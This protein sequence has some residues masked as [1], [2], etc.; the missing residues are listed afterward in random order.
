VD[1]DV[2]MEPPTKVKVIL[3]VSLILLSLQQL[4]LKVVV[5]EET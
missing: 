1:Q 4:E 3:V 2:E 5:E